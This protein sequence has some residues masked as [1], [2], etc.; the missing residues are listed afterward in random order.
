MLRAFLPNP[1]DLIA[2]PAAMLKMPNPPTGTS[3]LRTETFEDEPLERAVEPLDTPLTPA[4]GHGCL[5]FS[6]GQLLERHFVVG[7]STASEGPLANLVVVRDVRFKNAAHPFAWTG[8]GALE[9]FAARDLRSGLAVAGGRVWRAELR[10]ETRR[11]TPTGASWPL[12]GR[13]VSLQAL[14]DTLV[15]VH[16]LSPAGLQHLLV[17]PWTDVGRVLAEFEV[18]EPVLAAAQLASAAV[19][20][21]GTRVWAAYV[22]N[23]D[24]Q[25]VPRTVR[26]DLRQKAE[27]R[28]VRCSME[29]VN[30]RGFDLISPNPQLRF[31]LAWAD[32]RLYYVLNRFTPR[33]IADV[34][35]LDVEE[36]RWAK[37]RLPDGLHA[38]GDAFALLPEPRGHAGGRLVFRRHQEAT[39]ARCRSTLFE[40]QV[41]EED[42]EEEVDEAELREDPH[43]PL[44]EEW[45][46]RATRLHFALLDAA[47]DP[48]LVHSLRA[49]LEAAAARLAD[50]PAVRL[51]RAAMPLLVDPEDEQEEEEDEE[52]SGEEEKP[53]RPPPKPLSQPD[54]LPPPPPK[55]DS[56]PPVSEEAPVA[57]ARLRPSAA[58]LVDAGLEPSEDEQE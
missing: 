11:A 26:F 32:A 23:F 28:A 57:S 42:G 53:H 37:F 22:A 40:L 2:S 7:A 36:S 41:G 24:G 4:D 35:V 43:W 56:Q 18:E 33:Q 8:E 16:T 54:D 50:P 51:R 45:A 6:S 21:G 39:G 38:P 27:E 12:D 29:D 5:C 47:A 46:D 3:L 44:L 1:F 19:H 9:A 20:V 14:G 13:L 58:D 30:Y 25:M 15:F 34:F 52:E 31:S 48:A 55:P 49:A 10:A 17:R